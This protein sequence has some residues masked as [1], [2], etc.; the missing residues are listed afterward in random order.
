MMFGALAASLVATFASA[1]EP[2]RFPE[3]R[4]GTGKLKYINGLPVL[5]VAGSPEEI[6]EAVGVLAVR[7]GWRMAC[8]PE[9]L[10]KE[11]H[12]RPLWR[13]LVTAGKWM[14]ERFPDDYRREFEAMANSSGV[15][16]DRLVAGN[17]LFD[18]KKIMACSA[19]LVDAGR[20][21][22]GAPLLGRNLDYPSLGYAHEYSLVTVYRPKGARHAFATVGFPGLLGCL[23][24]MNDAGLA[25]AVLEVFQV[26]AGKRWFDAGGTPYALCYRRILEECSTIGEACDV[27]VGMRR[28]TTTNLVLADP[29]GVVVLEVTPN[30]VV[31]RGPEQGVCVCT[32]HFCTESLKPWLPFNFYH[33]FDR[34]QVLDQINQAQDRLG[35]A[36]LHQGLHA[37]RQEGET[38]QTMIFE[39]AARRLH[40][41]IGACP[42]SAAEL[43]VLDLDPLFHTPENTGQ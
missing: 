20:S 27:L 18:L 41:A 14:V 11:Y 24:G 13:P 37:A 3:G 42:S 8:Y 26:R 7:P 25:V 19:V 21:A 15:D 5:T 30:H 9:E 32:N 6:G 33:T 10:I 40:L 23:S 39:P 38:M 1:A 22:T 31:A 29:H 34:Y 43:K 4:H 35:I 28:T 36:D 16:R 12:L 2:F 17:T